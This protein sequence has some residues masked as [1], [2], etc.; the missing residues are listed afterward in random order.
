MPR[1]K[2]NIKLICK[3]TLP[4]TRSIKI[5]ATKCCGGSVLDDVAV[6]L[7]RKL[8]KMLPEVITVQI[9][10]KKVLIKLVKVKVAKYYVAVIANLSMLK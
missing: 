3:F 9:K 5:K 1:V 6:N 2:P 10:T 7:E 4:V 8:I